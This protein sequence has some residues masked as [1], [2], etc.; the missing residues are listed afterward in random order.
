MPEMVNKEEHKYHILFVLIEIVNNS[1]LVTL[2]C[3]KCI[4]TG[5]FFK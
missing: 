3:I 5:Q 2:A 1:Q 4:V